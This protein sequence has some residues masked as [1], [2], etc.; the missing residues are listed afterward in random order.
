MKKTDAKKQ[1]EKIIKNDLKTLLKRYSKTDAIINLERNY[2][3]D[4]I[5][6]INP[7]EIIESTFLKDNYFSKETLENYRRNL[8]ENVYLPLIIRN[9]ENGYEVVIGRELLKVAKDNKVAQINCV[10]KDF[11]NEETLLVLLSHL[12]EQKD[13]NIVDEAVLCKSLKEQY[14]YKNKDLAT[15][16][17]VSP[18]QISNMLNI[19]DLKKPILVAIAKGEIT[20]GHAKAFARLEREEID[21][22]F[23]L[24]KDNNLSVRETEKVVQA[25]KND[26]E[27]TQGISITKTKIIL[28]FENEIDKEKAI[29]IL[30]KLIKKG[31]I[32]VYK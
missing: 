3:R 24:I 1:D 14:G 11:N 13:T 5:K 19:L 16:L 9:V 22:V 10:V 28:S 12:R 15:F 29:P 2:S 20:Y 31:K 17:R 32:K 6:S 30:E 18:G 25:V 4:A 7:E 21:Q 23:K 26:E 8:E 27:Y